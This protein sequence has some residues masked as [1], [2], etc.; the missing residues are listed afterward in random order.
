MLPHTVSSS[1]DVISWAKFGLG[2]FATAAMLVAQIAMRP[3]IHATPNT[4][5]TVMCATPSRRRRRRRTP[6]WFLAQKPDLPDTI[7]QNAREDAR[8]K[9]GGMRGGRERLRRGSRRTT[10]RGSSRSSTGRA[11]AHTTRD[12]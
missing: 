9:E 8:G 11:T 10:C 3:Y 1:G 2:T 5:A 7:Y 12:A 6:L 4:A